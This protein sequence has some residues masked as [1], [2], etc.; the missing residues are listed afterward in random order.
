MT[1]RAAF[2]EDLIGRPY[3]IGAT[4]PDA[5][6]CYGLAR[7]VQSALY[8]VPMPA[9]P[10]VAA[11]TRAQA[12]AM[13][14]HEERRNWRETP[15][16]EARDGDLVLMGNVAKRDFHL[17]TFVV[18]GTAGVVLHVDQHAG[19]VADDIPALRSV[20]FNYLKFFRR[21]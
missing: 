19:V 7:H 13:L 18:P 17:G 21:I 10:F 15:E 5:F 3:R 6:D 16:H 2:L 4:G 9:L 14:A 8:A 1:Y 11:T 20:G 12:E